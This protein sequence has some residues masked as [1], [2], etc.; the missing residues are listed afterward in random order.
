VTE[1]RLRG[2]LSWFGQVLAWLVILGVAAILTVAVL[3]PRLSGATPY[4]VLT[5]S[6]R[7]SYP[8][9]TLVV[10]K[11]VDADRIRVGDVIT[12]QLESGKPAVATHRVT[13][14]SH[15]LAGETRFTTQGDANESPDADP[16]RP[17]QVRGQLWY[18]VP[19]LGYVNNVIT[20]SQR[21]WAI[22]IVA[23]GLLGYAAAMFVAAFGER[24]RP[25][26]V[27]S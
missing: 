22:L 23:V 13:E 5:G 15:N 2:S 18:A 9:G 21:R 7:P 27:L 4:T 19:Y 16:V 10:V 8:P 26:H 20:A 11:P 14:I 1:R 25:R 6:M 3:G 12:Y 24:R 17:V